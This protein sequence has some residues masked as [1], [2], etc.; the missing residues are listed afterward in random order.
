MIDEETNLPK[1]G[2]GDGTR[3]LSQYHYLEPN[4]RGQNEG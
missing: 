3:F 1:P 4:I 2:S